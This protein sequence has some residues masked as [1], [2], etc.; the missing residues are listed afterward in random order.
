MYKNKNILAKLLEK[1]LEIKIDNINY[2]NSEIPIK[3]FIE[4]GKRLDLYIEITDTFVDIEVIIK[5]SINRTIN[6]LIDK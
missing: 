3:Q 5:P 2:L 4:K 1:I 6:E